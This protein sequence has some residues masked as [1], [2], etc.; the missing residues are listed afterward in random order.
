M[1][2]KKD[3]CISKNIYLKTILVLLKYEKI[4]YYLKLF[5]FGVMAEWFMAFILNVNL[6]YITKVRILLTLYILFFF[7]NSN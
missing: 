7:L 6:F 1:L 4:F 3:Y 2:K 5:Y